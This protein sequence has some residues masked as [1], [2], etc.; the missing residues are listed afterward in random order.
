MV[1][2]EEKIYK[3]KINVK[4]LAYKRMKIIHNDE[5]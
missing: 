1:E 4:K 2:K 3:W 5:N